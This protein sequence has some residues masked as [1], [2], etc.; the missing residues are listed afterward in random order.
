MNLVAAPGTDTGSYRSAATVT[1]D[2][3]NTQ[4]AKENQKLANEHNL[5]SSDNY[6]SNIY[7]W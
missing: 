6:S 4:P 2:N 3:I 5:T 1:P 7:K